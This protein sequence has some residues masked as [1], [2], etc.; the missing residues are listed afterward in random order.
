MLKKTLSLLFRTEETRKI[1]LALLTEVRNRQNIENPYSSAEY[2]EF[3]KKNN[4]SEASYQSV[5]SILRE[6]G[7]LVKSGGHHEGKLEINTYFVQQLLIE[8]FEFLNAKY[9]NP[10]ES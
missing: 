4:F 2:H 7:L 10:E 1:A 8:L 9:K 5:L 3:C 6:N